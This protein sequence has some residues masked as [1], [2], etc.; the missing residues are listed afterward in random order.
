MR[1][2]REFTAIADDTRIFSRRSSKGQ[3][4]HNHRLDL[5]LDP[6]ENGH[7]TMHESNHD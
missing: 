5:D 6:A 3:A 2:F 7:K 4:Q 1:F